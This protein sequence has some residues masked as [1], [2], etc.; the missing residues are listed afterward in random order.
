MLRVKSIDQIY[1]EVKEFDL[2]ITVDAPLR[3]ALNRRVQKPMLDVFAA[4]PR[5]LSLKHAQHILKQPIM[6]DSEFVLWLSRRTGI[7]L[8]A[9]KKAD[10]KSAHYYVKK[11]GMRQS[12]S[13]GLNYIDNKEKNI[14]DLISTMPSVYSALEKFDRSV[15][16]GK[17][18]AVIGLNFFTQ[19]DRNILPENYTQIDIF[20]DDDYQLPAFYAFASEKDVVDRVI[21]LINEENA[22]DIAIVLD[23]ESSYLPLIKSRLI[24]KGIPLNSTEQLRDNFRARSFLRLIDIGLNMAGLKINEI[25]PIAELFSLKFPPENANYLLSEYVNTTDNPTVK[26]LYEFINS[27]SDRTYKEVLDWL[28]NNGVDMPSELR[29]A[30]RNLS[31]LDGKVNFDSYASLLYYIENFDIEVAI[32]SEGVLLVDCR[33]SAYIDRPVCFYIG[34]DASWASNVNWESKEERDRK[35]LDMFQVLLQQGQKRYFI[36]STM[37]KNQPATPCYYFNIIFSKKIDG[38]H[39]PVFNTVNIQNR[40]DTNRLNDIKSSLEAKPK[41]ITH[42]SESALSKFA[43]CPRK[44]AYSRLTDLE[45]QENMRRGNLLHEFATFY[46]NHPDI[47]N[48]KDDDFFVN[49]MLKKHKQLAGD[50]K[51]EIDRSKYR[52]G[53]QNIREFIDNLDIDED[54]D[55]MKITE[56]KNKKENNFAKLL[57][58]A[59]EKKNAE[60]KF[61]DDDIYLMGYIDLVANDSTIVDYKSSSSTRFPSD[62]TKSAI[63]ELIKDKVDFQPLVYLLE[64][65]KLSPHPIEL[66]YHFCLSNQNKVVN[67]KQ[68]IDEN[69]VKAKYHHKTFSE[70]LQTE[71]AINLI[72]SSKDREKLI[73]QIGTENLIEFFKY[74]PIPRDL[75]FDSD[76]LT[77]AEYSDILSDYIYSKTGEKIE[78]D[79]IL[80]AIVNIRLGSRQNIALFFK[81]DLDNF[82]LFVR[83]QIGKINSHIEDNFPCEPLTRD[84][85]DN[86]DYADICLKD[87]KCL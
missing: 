72:A 59:I 46:F 82:E 4:T 3:T 9:A 23:P 7:A 62:I 67:G 31:V 65:R 38:F 22:D 28:R 26:Q 47:V 37:K 14:L 18:L 63:Y 78:A 84:I 44:Y 52:I 50:N 21:S 55:I 36:V 76:K 33:D 71:E 6:E 51:I 87:N 12:K 10:I 70:F 13:E 17:N 29:E 25:N 54:L 24:N 19:L 75:Q 45:D 80:K 41:H 8:E 83:D 74:N 49:E 81:D 60:F 48:D 57:G 61:E 79:D 77:K 69:I 68:Q 30:L 32:S 40:Y 73:G 85:C 43:L 27:I 53:V 2:V 34:L 58:V 42:L 15:F 35:S 39:D 66:I 56:Q 86:C 5:E 20:T 64:I 11:I 16:R 1:D